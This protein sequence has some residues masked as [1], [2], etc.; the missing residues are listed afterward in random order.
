[1]SFTTAQALLEDLMGGVKDA[2]A[3]ETY[4]GTPGNRGTFDFAMCDDILGEML[5]NDDVA[6]AAIVGSSTARNQL[7]KSGKGMENFAAALPA[8]LAGAASSTFMNELVTFGRAIYRFIKSPYL[9]PACQSGTGYT[10]LAAAQALGGSKLK[11][12]GVTS[13]SYNTWT[14]PSANILWM[15]MLVGGTGGN[16]ATSPT[17]GHG[18][19]GGAGHIVGKSFEGDA[20]PP[21][22]L[23]MWAAGNSNSQG[24]DGQSSYIMPEGLG[25]GNLTGGSWAQQGVNDMNLRQYSSEDQAYVYAPGGEG[26][27]QTTLATL[28]YEEQNKVWPDNY[29]SLFSRMD[30]A[31]LMDQDVYLRNPKI[32][33]NTSGNY[34]NNN[35]GRGMN[36][37]IGAHSATKATLGGTGAYASVPATGYCAGGWYNGSSLMNGRSGF[38][39]IWHIEE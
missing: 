12:T 39:A 2:T 24:D 20:I 33:R 21:G 1:M 23:Y 36:S 9:R 16:P 8:M 4:L 15:Y 30:N 5:F 26:V 22:D 37:P 18:G 34:Q 17:G 3:L 13:G 35:N 25:G 14:R 28:Q 29:G 27:N 31:P 10:N 38:A 7:F 6:L 19:G 32:R 11:K